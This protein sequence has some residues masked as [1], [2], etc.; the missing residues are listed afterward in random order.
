MRMHAK[1][2]FAALI[3]TSSAVAQAPKPEEV[4]A[5]RQSLLK[6]VLWNF[7]P[8]GA[9]VKGA[10][11]WDAAEFKRRSVAVAFAALQLDEA[12]PAG[13]DQG[14]VT[15]ALPAIWE[16]P[17][18]FKAK[19]RDFQLAANALRIA[20]VGGDQDTIKREFDH[21]RNTCKACHQDYRAD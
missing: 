16:N 19:L 4:I 9:M 17:D 3:V 6:T 20:T 1:I 11:P 14:G 21:V 2:L 18:D 10:K 8:M 7:A 5:Y 13:S 12:F 15:D